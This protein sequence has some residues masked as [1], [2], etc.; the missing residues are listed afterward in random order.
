MVSYEKLNERIERMSEIVHCFIIKLNFW[1]AILTSFIL[2]AIN[3]YVS[4]LGDDSF[5]LIAL[6]MYAVC[7]INESI[8][9][10]DFDLCSNTFVLFL[11]GIRSI[12]KH[13]AVI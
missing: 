11:K 10:G 1:G 5:I 4:D 12:G 2:S 3:Y 9:R 13:P 7:G 8:F 6:A